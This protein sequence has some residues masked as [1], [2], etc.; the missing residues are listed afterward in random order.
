[1][2]TPKILKN[3]V[4][5]LKSIKKDGFA[6][7]NY[8]LNVLEMQGSHCS[9]VYSIQVQTG[10]KLDVSNEILNFAYIDGSYHF[11]ELMDDKA[12]EYKFYKISKEKDLVNYIAKIMRNNGIFFG[13]KDVEDIKYNI[14]DL[15][16]LDCDLQNSKYKID[17]DEYSKSS[18]DCVIN[19]ICPVDS[20]ASKKIESKVV[21]SRESFCLETKDLW[22]VLQ[23][24]FPSVGDSSVVTTAYDLIGKQ[25][26]HA[27]LY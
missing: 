26:F 8:V 25:I 14:F 20:Y 23:Q 5:I 18:I 4:I 2:P 13:G 7:A 1:M 21:D 22:D 3:S 27:G 24:D 17:L 15:L 19:I 16:G 9:F 10:K 12:M 11:T 6:I